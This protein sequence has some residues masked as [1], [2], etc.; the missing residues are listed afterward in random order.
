M[1]MHMVDVGVLVVHGIL[2]VLEE[3]P[4]VWVGD[5]EEE[6]VVVVGASLQTWRMKGD[7]QQWERMA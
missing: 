3:V 1:V 5:L 6:E 7:G 4:P 2:L